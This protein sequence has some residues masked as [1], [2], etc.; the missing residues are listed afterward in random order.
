MTHRPI[1][2][3]FLLQSVD[4]KIT[5]GASDALDFDRD[6]PR[7]PGLREGLHQYYEIGADHRPVVAEFRAGAGENGGKQ[8]ASAGKNAGFLC[9]F[10]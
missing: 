7:I 5:T 1:T 4:G 3:L 9:D 8:K 2:T 6:F 10:R